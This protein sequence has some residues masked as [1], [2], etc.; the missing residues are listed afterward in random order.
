MTS[1]SSRR[2][3]PR[4]PWAFLT[5]HALTLVEVNRTP[6]ATVRELAARMSLTER[7]VHRVL[8]DLVN[9][10][11]VTRTRQGRRNHYSI[12]PSAP[13][14]HASIAHHDVG[15]LIAVLSS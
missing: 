12:D 13:M 9:A 2:R 4:R 7:Q 14:R 6:N 1:S 10:G 15:K 5:S 3:V 8:D 11:Y